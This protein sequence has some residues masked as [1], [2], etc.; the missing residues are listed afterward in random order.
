MSAEQGGGRSWGSRRVTLC[1]VSLFALPV[2]QLSPREGKIMESLREREREANLLLRQED[3]R[4]RVYIGC[5]HMSTELLLDQK[6]EFCLSLGP[7]QIK[8]KTQRP[9]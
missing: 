5:S 9:L 6:V 4:A 3:A 7:R 8:I 2:H 1:V